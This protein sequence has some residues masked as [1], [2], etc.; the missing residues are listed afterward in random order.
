MEINIWCLATGYTTKNLITGK[1]G[2]AV[3]ETQDFTLT[4]ILMSGAVNVK[5][6]I[7]AMCWNLGQPNLTLFVPECVVLVA[8]MT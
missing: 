4:K 8:P 3:L 1:H 2:V 5:M 7:L 6:I